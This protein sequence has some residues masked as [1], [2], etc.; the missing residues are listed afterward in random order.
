[1]YL[2]VTYEPVEDGVSVVVA[3]SPCC[4]VAYINATQ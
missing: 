1:M 3:K 2:I 4:G